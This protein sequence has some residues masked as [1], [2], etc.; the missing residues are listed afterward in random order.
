MNKCRAPVDC[1]RYFDCF[2]RRLDY[3]AIGLR[4]SKLRLNSVDKF[5]PTPRASTPT[6]SINNTAPIGKSFVPDKS[7]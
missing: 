3:S 1:G 2:P 4:L 7:S 5:E 6:P